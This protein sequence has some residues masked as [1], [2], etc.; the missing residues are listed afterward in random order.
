MKLECINI[1]SKNPEK[2]AE[3]YEKL[4]ISV[5]LIAEIMTDLTLEMQ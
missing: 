3:F 1:S 2:L 4:G 5:L